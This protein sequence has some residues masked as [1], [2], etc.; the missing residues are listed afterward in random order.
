MKLEFNGQPSFTLDQRPFFSIIIPCYNSGKTIG[1]LLDSIYAQNMNDEIEVIISD[2]N[3][4]E[5]YFDIVERYAD[6]ISIRLIKTDYN[7]APGNTREKGV[8]IAEGIWV[9][10]AD[11]DDEFIPETLPVVKQS[12]IES[13]EQYYAIANFIE[14]NPDTGEVIRE[15]IQYRNWNHAKF[16]NLDN[17]WKANNIHFKKD[18]LTHE[19]IYISSRINCAMQQYGDDP[20]AVDVF[21]Y[22]WNNRPTSISR[23]IYGDHSFLEVFFKD[24]IESTGRVYLDQVASGKISYDYGLYS[25]VEVL[26]YCYFYT[27]SFKFHDPKGWIRE[28]DDYSRSYLTDIKQEF[29]VDN[30]KIMEIVSENDAAM[31]C[32]VRESAIMGCGPHV[33]EKTLRQWLDFLHKD[34][35]PRITMS[36]AMKKVH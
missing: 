26:L 36:D 15:M 28:N 30:D 33:P 22:I 35:K 18:L 3:S 34:I 31:F 10:F 27:E 13:G 24:Y 20:L 5:P 8:S 2:D 17:L 6:E 9:C 29:K 11:H 21:C 4:T 14:A 19:D 16:Y 7:F 23:E 1:K 32:G 25:V 12:I